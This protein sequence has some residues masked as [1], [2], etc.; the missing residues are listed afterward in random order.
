MRFQLRP[1]VRRLFRLAPNSSEGVRAEFDDELEAL[2]AS[3]V[4]HLIKHG[5]SAEDA[6]REALRRLGSTLDEVRDHLRTTANQ[7]GRKMSVVD[8]IESVAQDVHYA[9]RGLARRPVFTAVAVVTLAIG[10]GATTAIF[11][12]VSAL[13]LR[14]LPYTRPDELMKLS[15]VMPGRGNRPTNFNQQWSYPKFRFFR[16]AQRAFSEL[17]LYE[18]VQATLT[19][20]DAERVNVERVG[21]TYLR[22]LGLRP[23]VGHDFDRGL[24]AVPGAAHQVLLS[25]DLWRHRYNADPSVVGRTVQIGTDTWTI[26]GVAPAGFAG[27]TGRVQLFTLLTAMTAEDLADP[28]LHNYW[29]V[30]RRAP[31]VNV[32]QAKA[33]TTALGPRIS[34]A[35]PSTFQPA[36]WG[37]LAAPLNDARL[38]PSV[39]RSLLILFGSVGFVLLIA[40][41]NVAS[42]LLGRAGARGR[43]IAVRL[44]LGAGRAR[45][46]R[47]LVTESLL[48]AAIGAVASV[49]VAWLGVRALSTIDPATTLRVGRET[50]FGAMAFSNLALDWRALAFA[51]GVSVAVG[52]L[53]GLAP[54]GS[55]RADLTEALKSG[56]TSRGSR[57]PITRRV[58]VLTEVA[59]A[60]VLLAG[61]GLMMRTLGNLLR[62]KPGFDAEQVLSFRL[63]ILGESR[64]SLPGFYR[65]LADR[66]GAIPGVTNVALGSCAPL[67]G[68][69]SSTLFA[70]LDRPKVE[71]GLMPR[72]RLE[73]VS[74]TW[75]STMHVPLKRG[76]GFTDA[77]R[78]GTPNVT[79]LNEAAAR[80]FFPNEDPIGKHITI[81]IRGLDD[82]E[83]IGVAGDVRIN[84]DSAA[85]PAA[86]IPILQAPRLAMMIFVRSTREPGSLAPEIRNAMRDVAPRA[87]VYDMQT[88]TEREAAA[89]AKTRFSTT[90]LALFAVTALLLAAIGIYGVMALAVTARTR[91]I[92]IRMAL[93]ADG[94]RIERAVIGEGMGLV[95]AGALIG[96]GAAVMSTRVLRSLLFDL[97]PTDPVT[98]VAIVALIAVTAAAASWVPAR[99]AANVDP[100]SSLRSE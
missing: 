98:Y 61:A 43:E 80:S 26:I 47:L 85:P 36:P 3:R 22:V 5:M 72:I 49:A 71:G 38:D 91:E 31:G 12:A 66:V 95:G 79:I 57:A 75:F 34:A 39:K 77:D 52:I 20:G 6:R 14:P 89:T 37:A 64:D 97:S 59:L 41:V 2:I 84:I 69:C 23:V 19:D 9:A 33:A 29:L 10:I 48:L 51:V 100:L 45:L 70:R 60:V 76:R 73:W 62:V 25:H 13:L 68:G 27:L 42:L 44:A 7:R 21:A 87:P 92:G 58:L 46:V 67:T 81:G 11:S 17:A 54:A 8:W 35:Y 96:L 55:T 90:L 82:V 65:E 30:A 94:R 1:G 83:V 78:V 74:T 63:S 15:I 18:D 16:D 28:Q 53:F 24:D 4:D 93:G 56:R 32:A 88:L 40:C 86:L 99:R 50:G